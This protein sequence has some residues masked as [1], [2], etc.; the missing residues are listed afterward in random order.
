MKQKSKHYSSSTKGFS[1]IELLVYIAIV[2][3]L[4]GVILA[5]VSAARL[6]GRDGRRVADVGRI[7]LALEQ[8]KDQNGVYPPVTYTSGA[9]LAGWEVSFYP[10]FL[11]GLDPYMSDNPNDPVNAG[12]PVFTDGGGSASP[13]FNTRPDGSYFYMYYNYPSGSS[14]GCSFS[15]PFSIIGFRSVEGKSILPSELPKASCGPNPCTGGSYPGID[16]PRC[17]DWSSEFDYSVMLIQ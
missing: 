16:V 8:Y 2:M 13:M 7:I 17:R 6:K 3:V 12:P 9:N 15:G 5:S 1:L 10:D 4:S 11:E 14:Y